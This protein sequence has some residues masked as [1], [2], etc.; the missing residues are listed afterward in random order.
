[1][2]ICIINCLQWVGFHLTDHLLNAG[3]VI[4]G[5]DRMDDAYK[6]NLAEFMIRNSRFT[7][8]H[9][10]SDLPAGSEAR[11]EVNGDVADERPIATIQ[12]ANPCRQI[13]IQANL[14]FGLWM[15]MN[16]SCVRWRGESIMLESER[17]SNEAVWAADFAKCVQQ[18]LE[19]GLFPESV[20]LLNR[21]SEEKAKKQSLYILES[22]TTKRRKKE[23]LRHYHNFSL[24]YP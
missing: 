23:L 20:T 6:E 10:V 16:R 5:I 21:H 2:K 17:L 4:T 7:L 22:E 13:D 1:M 3:H 19:S 9:S 12:L 18:I 14:L 24:L 8:L 11:I 15:P